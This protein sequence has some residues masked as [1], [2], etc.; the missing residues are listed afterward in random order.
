MT[1]ADNLLA[2]ALAYDDAIE[3]QLKDE[4]KPCE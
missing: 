4:D 1:D 2:D 3:A